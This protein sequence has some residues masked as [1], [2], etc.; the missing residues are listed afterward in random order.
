MSQLTF[1]RVLLV[2]PVVKSPPVAPPVPSPV[3]SFLNADICDIMVCLTPGVKLSIFSPCSF[4]HL[5]LVFQFG[6]ILRHNPS[7]FP[8]LSLALSFTLSLSLCTWQSS[9]TSFSYLSSSYDILHHTQRLMDE[10]RLTKAT[11]ISLEPCAIPGNIDPRSV[12]TVALTEMWLRAKWHI[13][14]GAFGPTKAYYHVAM[15]HSYSYR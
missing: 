6:S 12:E 2:Q 9:N 13:H 5:S 14:K 7:H 10:S 15:L 4:L 8:P 3:P 11:S 1:F